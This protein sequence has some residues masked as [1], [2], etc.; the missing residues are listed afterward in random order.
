MNIIF[1][2]AGFS[3]HLEFEARACLYYIRRLGIFR[4]EYYT[5]LKMPR[6][7]TRLSLALSTVRFGSESLSGLTQSSFLSS[8]HG[9]RLDLACSSARF[10]RSPAQL[11]GSAHRNSTRLGSPFGTRHIPARGSGSAW[12]PAGDSGIS[13]GLSWGIR[14]RF[15]LAQGSIGSLVSAW[16]LGSAWGL[17]RFGSQVRLEVR[18]AS[19]CI[20][21]AFFKLSAMR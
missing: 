14:I 16:C 9:S 18:P 10:A 8:R 17:A 5:C 2:V 3:M 1:L 11:Q 4:H 15:S 6:L 7:E 13:S 20:P 19:I 21:N 12:G